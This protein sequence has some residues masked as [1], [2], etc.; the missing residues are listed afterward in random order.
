M[1]TTTTLFNILNS[2]LARMGF[3][4]IFD[5]KTQQFITTDSKNFTTYQFAEFTDLAYKATTEELF[6]SIILKN[7]DADRYFKQVFINRFLLREIKF[8]T[9]DM[10][11]SKLVSMYISDSQYITSLY[12]YYDDLLKGTTTGVSHGTS[13]TTGNTNSTGTNKQGG[14]RSERSAT[15]DLPQD[16]PDLDLNN[17]T[18]DFPSSTDARKEKTTSDTDTTNNTNT[19]SDT[20]TQ[21]NTES[22]TISVDNLIKLR[23]LYDDLL[24]K[25]ER[26]LFLN[27]W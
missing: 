6:A 20:V 7:A 21:N 19:K 8:Q 9:L 22:Q 10:F 27:I 25:Y 24:K 26:S 2:K 14:T 12:S 3:D 23:S 4:G 17:D 16:L 18:I 5:E 1:A 13:D 11:R 15:R